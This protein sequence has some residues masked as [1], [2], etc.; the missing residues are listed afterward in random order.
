[1]ASKDLAEDWLYEQKEHDKDFRDVLER[2]PCAKCERAVE[3]LIRKGAGT[4]VDQGCQ[5]AIPDEWID[6]LARQLEAAITDRQAEFMAALKEG[7]DTSDVAEMLAE[8]GRARRE[9]GERK[10]AA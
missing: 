6:G 5:C 7:P 3:W 10:G 1:M 2:R 4:N 8:R 9:M